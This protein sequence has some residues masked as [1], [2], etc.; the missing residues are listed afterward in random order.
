MRAATA[1]FEANDAVRNQ[2]LLALLP[3][4]TAS[5]E[6]AKDNQNV[7]ETG[8]GNTGRFRFNS[9]TY[10]LTLR[11]PL[12]RQDLFSRVGQT[13][14]QVVQAQAE[15]R[16]AQQAFTVRV[17]ERYFEVL[18][19]QDNLDFARANREAAERQLAL[20][21]ARH[22]VGVGAL[23][24]LR[25][26]EA[27]HDL[28]IA[29][30]IDAES[31]VA[32][33]DE[34][35]RELTGDY[36]ANLRRLKP[37]IPL[38]VPNPPI[39]DAWRQHAESEN[40]KLLAMLGAAQVAEKEVSRQRAGHYPSLDFVGTKSDAKNGG[41]F[42]DSRIKDT[43]VALELNVPLFASGQISAHVREAQERSNQARELAEQQRR[44]VVRQASDA[45]RAVTAGISRI[46][47]L[48]RSM[49]S[50]ETALQA[51]QAGYRAG[52]RTATD[53][54]AAQRTHLKTRR[55]HAAERYAY[56]VNTLRLKEAAGMLS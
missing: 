14:A 27:S 32:S 47:A 19:A 37:E 24:D 11:Q 15:L 42:G 40:Q 12:F 36:P 10:S 52:T 51:V 17:A 16:A 2:S 34:A 43:I 4:L 20:T 35:L 44:A 26:V 33:A 30:E 53:V 7:L 54:I 21:R 39:I 41:R 56:V 18:A 3:S 28:T 50:T 5:G 6:A 38:L 46:N 55:D 48:E 8:V 45:Y 1:A 13:G 22:N 25:E 49:A 29:Q 9:S 23:T 31:R